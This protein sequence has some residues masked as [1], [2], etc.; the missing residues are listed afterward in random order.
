MTQYYILWFRPKIVTWLTKILYTGKNIQFGKNLRID[1]VPRIIVGKNSQLKIGNNVEIRRNVEIRAHINSVITIEDNVKIDRG[2]RL[3]STNQAKIHIQKGA[4]IG[5][6]SVFNG[7]DS[8]TIGEKSL[9]SGFV[10]IQT[11][12]HGFSQRTTSIQDQGYEHAPITIGKNSW[13]AAHVVILPG[14]ILNEGTIV[15]SNAVVTKNSTPFQILA[16]VPA[17]PIKERD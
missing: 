5:L 14:I 1:S 11:S 8:I 4:R 9:I 13:L 16:G 10:Y 3:L 6:Y 12:N 15:G 7:G 2:V 17:K